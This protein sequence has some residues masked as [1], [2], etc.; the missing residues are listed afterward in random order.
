[1]K[2]IL[3]YTLLAL[4]AVILALS[5][6]ITS[7]SK[8]DA[9]F[10]KGIVDSTFYMPENHDLMIWLRGD[11]RTFYIN[12]ALEKGIDVK[13]FPKELEGKIIMIAYADQWTALDP[14]ESFRH[15]N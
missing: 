12:R 2:K 15:V 9:I 8:D 7:T 14:F 6:R 1:M 4:V 3:F 13:I 5:L 10:I 11:K